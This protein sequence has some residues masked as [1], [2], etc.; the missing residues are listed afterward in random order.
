MNPTR[1]RG[2]IFLPLALIMVSDVAPTSVQYDE[3][4]CS[5]LEEVTI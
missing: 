3:F 2:H 5:Q 1:A 4:K